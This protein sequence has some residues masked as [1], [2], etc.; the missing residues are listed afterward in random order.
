M[1]GILFLLIFGLTGFGIL[2]ALGTWQIQRL[3]W[4]QAILTQ[5]ESRISAA[6]VALPAQ[7][8]R[9]RD[10][11]LPVTATGLVADGVR[12]LV[13]VKQ[14]GPGYRMINVFETGG[15]R[16]LL[17]RGFLPIE[18]HTDNGRPLNVSVI[19]NLHWP[20]EVD[21]YTP[22]PEEGTWFARDVDA[23]AAALNTEPV[24]IIAK[25]IDPQLF[26]TTPMPVDTAAIPN[27][28]LQYAITWF[29]LALIW[30]VM[31]ASFLWRTR[32]KTTG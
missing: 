28:H 22:A 21:S 14:R 30:L 20:Q 29:S 25:T 19:G 6:P 16:I 12:V 17:D 24:L 10:K 1:R 32:A 7:P 23:M 31:T 2:V 18:A 26:S 4:K 13:S 9:D 11:Y 27:N 15:R 3:S 8:H 5:I